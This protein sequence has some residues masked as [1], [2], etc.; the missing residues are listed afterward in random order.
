MTS[1]S[2]L[3]F[4]A[5][6]LLF[7][8]AFRNPALFLLGVLLGLVA[9]ASA[10]WGRYCL[11]GVAYDRRFSQS[12]LFCGEDVELWVE[13]VNAK[14]LPLAWL[15][16]EDRF[17]A[18]LGRQNFELHYASEPDHR[19]LTNLFSIN[20]Y[21]RVRRRYRLTAHRRGAFEFGPVIISS[22][23]IF[24]FR[25]RYGQIDHRHTLL[26]YPKVA[27]L[28]SLGLQAA[29]PFGELKTQRRLIAD[30]LRLAGTRDYQPGE[31]TR[32]IHWKATARRGS[33]QTKVFDPSASQHLLIF[34][35]NQSRE[36]HYEGIM[37]DLFETAVVVA[38]SLA[39][40]ALEARHPVGLFTN[41]S[42]R[43]SQR[44]ARI[45]ASRRTDQRARILE[46][47]AQLFYFSNLQF[48]ELLRLEAPGLPYGATVIAV[49]AVVN[50]GLLSSLLDLRAGGHPVAL[51][52]IGQ[53]TIV[54]IPPE[55]PTYFVTRNWTE[56]EVIAISNY[57]RS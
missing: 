21:E 48:D 37:D 23:D 56:M 27:A 39:H 4:L 15:K 35:N 30:P 12:R 1:R 18:E 17:P 11:E 45:P 16:T 19:L 44:R 32:H 43:G 50:D 57:Q 51:I 8:L 29:R 54:S 42:L 25:T 36:R 28:D 46:A 3:L 6:V 38:A 24:G 52:I 14:P 34:L 13:V 33:L 9:A 31:D 26:V 10:V 55:L 5:L 22:G 2:L 7:S 40:A 53:P 20:W 47:L 49:S 41:G